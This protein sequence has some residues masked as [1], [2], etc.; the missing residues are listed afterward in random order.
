[1]RQANVGN[2]DLQLKSLEGAEH[3]DY[4]RTVEAMPTESLDFVLVDGRL[5][6]W[7][8][9]SAL[10]KLKPGGLLILD[11]AESH[12]PR[13]RADMKT[14]HETMADTF[15]KTHLETIVTRMTSWRT[16][17]TYNGIWETRFWIKP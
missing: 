5:R 6:G 2:V 13:E 8:M 17:T 7:C 9:L 14:S 11:N 10:E 3:S 1:L 15:L 16:I 12:F 4:V